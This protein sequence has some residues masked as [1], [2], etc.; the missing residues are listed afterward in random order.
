QFFLGF[1][2]C[3]RIKHT[4]DPGDYVVC[5]TRPTTGAIPNEVELRVQTEPLGGADDPGA[6]AL[7]DSANVGALDPLDIAC[8][9]VDLAATTNLVATTTSA[10]GTCG[11]QFTALELPEVGVDAVADDGGGRFTQCSRINRTL[12]AG[13]QLVCLERERGSTSSALTLLTGS[14]D[15]GFDDAP[16]PTSFSDG[17]IIPLS[18]SPSGDGDCFSFDP[19]GP[20]DVRVRFAVAGDPTCSALDTQVNLESDTLSTGFLSGVTS[21]PDFNLLPRACAGIGGFVQDSTTVCGLL[22][23]GETADASLVLEVDDDAVLNPRPLPGAPFIDTIAPEGDVD[24]FSFTVDAAEHPSLL[25]EDVSG[26]HLPLLEI[27]D[28]TTHDVVLDS[29][30]LFQQ[31]DQDF[32]RDFA[33]LAFEPLGGSF[34]ACLSGA[35]G[36]P[37]GDTRVSFVHDDVGDPDAPTLTAFPVDVTSALDAGDVDCFQLTLPSDGNVTFRADDGNGCAAPIGLSLWE[38][39]GELAAA[40]GPD[41]TGTCPTI[42]FDL[43]A[44]DYSVCSFSR[45]AASA[46]RVTGLLDAGGGLTAPVAGS[47]GDNTVTLD[48]IGDVDCV[49]LDASAGATA[50]VTVAPVDDPSCSR[51]DAIGYLSS[52]T[53][54]QLVS[55]A[56]GRCPLFESIANGPLTVCAQA[57]SAGAVGDVVLSVISDDAFGATFSNTIGPIA[58]DTPVPLSFPIQG[59]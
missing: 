54:V 51:G 32:N 35:G 6:L 56:P 52:Q 26:F 13:A 37:I 7:P 49:S 36:V 31:F 53:T 30:D 3:Q 15:V 5:A 25:V 16:A 9:R 39:G 44:G 28:A 23:L 34:E 22:A 14:D 42:N 17:A 45:V 58:L 18:V 33:V 46:V 1:G 11:T 47:L 55:A 48:S 43:F 50:L 24:C 57:N 12:A 59:D 8:F 2:Q 21:F 40:G 4:L 38:G 29:N 10:D 27:R 20:L 41:F 19:G